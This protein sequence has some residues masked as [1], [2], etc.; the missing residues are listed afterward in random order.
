MGIN[1]VDLKEI[2][3][4]LKTPF[5]IGAEED[6]FYSE[7]NMAVLKRRIADMKA[8]RNVTEH[9]L[10]EEDPFYSE[11]N[12]ERLR[13]SIAQLNAGKGTVHELIEVD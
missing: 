9:E 6:P 5:T 12:M 3:S 8:G 2:S 10:I 4:D 11:E 13:R 1:R 7:E